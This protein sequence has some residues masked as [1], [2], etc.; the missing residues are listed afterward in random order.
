MFKPQKIALI[1][2][3][4]SHDECLYAQVAYLKS[5]P[6]CS[7]RIYCSPK[8]A[9]RIA[10]WADE[11]EVEILK[12]KLGWKDFYRLYKN[13]SK[14]QFNTVIFNTG[15]GP[16]IRKL[17]LFP[18]AK[19]IT[20][21]ASI[22][23]I[24]RLETSRSQKAISRKVRKYL[25]L[26]DYLLKPLAEKNYPQLKFSSYYAIL[27][28]SYPELEIAKPAGEIWIVIPGQVE[29]KRRDYPSLIQALTK[30]KP[31]K[32]LRFILLGISEHEH[33][34][35]ILL[36]AEIEA[37]GLE[38]NFMLWRDF[39]SMETFYT[40][41]KKA[42][43]IMPLIHAEHGSGRTYQTQ[44]SGTYNLAFA[45]K[46]CLL[47]DEAYQDIEDFKDSAEFYQTSNLARFLNGL[48]S[49]SHKK[50]YQLPKWSFYYQAE[51]YW[52]FIQN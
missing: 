6:K 45:F 2:L 21:I 35:G 40:Y 12:Q 9:A 34:D 42:D 24:N 18:F 4:T 38:E 32:K 30:E 5:R 26:N 49:T 46:K 33:G 8:I 52:N 29:N 17:L 50:L 23:N 44:I 25:V 31:S 16:H 3:G 39:V 1:E 51:K 22:H 10:P 36:K 13:I 27:Y 14:G 15:Q 43:Y 41:V 19:S 7:L 20:F 37:A 47:M 28:P 48:E 11:N